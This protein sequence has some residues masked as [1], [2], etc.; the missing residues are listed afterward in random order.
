MRIR[1]LVAFIV[2]AASLMFVSSCSEKEKVTVPG[3]DMEE[4]YLQVQELNES[5][6]PLASYLLTS[7]LNRTDGVEDGDYGYDLELGKAASPDH[8]SVFVVY[9]ALSGWWE[10]FFSTHSSH[11][12]LPFYDVHW[13][14]SIQFRS[15]TG[16]T[17]FLPDETT[18]FVHGIARVEIEHISEDEIPTDF[19]WR[20]DVRYDDLT[21]ETIVV[22][23]EIRLEVSTTIDTLGKTIEGTA[24]VVLETDDLAIAKPISEAGTACAVS[25]SVTYSLTENV[26]SQFIGD[27]VVFTTW[28][29]DVT[30]LD[31][32][33][34]RVKV[35][36][37][38]I[39]FDEY[40]MSIDCSLGAATMID[41]VEHV[42][43]SL[44]GRTR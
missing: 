29:V 11:E 13:R 20:S 21:E 24:I 3:P 35:R 44:V 18:D 27:Q 17:Q 7:G 5:I 25:G 37:G 8:D 38:N 14:D 30:V 28:S 31:Q 22:D 41:A 16:A 26:S 9:H 4:Q 12:E 2:A 39:E 10:G 33:T 32:Q 15:T 23:G 1:H 34:Y 40:E 19:G 36:A 6:V 42:A 43:R